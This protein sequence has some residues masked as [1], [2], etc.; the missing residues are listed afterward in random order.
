LTA[1]AIDFVDGLM[2]SGLRPVLWRRIV[3]DDDALGVGHWIVKVTGAY[4]TPDAG[5]EFDVGTT[6]GVVFGRPDDVPPPPP[7]PAMRAANPKSATVALVRFVKR[8]I[9]D[10]SLQNHRAYERDVPAD[11]RDRKAMRPL[12]ERHKNRRAASLKRSNGS[13]VNKGYLI[14]GRARSSGLLARFAAA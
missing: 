5:A 4:W 6:P 11:A 3:E 10:P 2:Y 12:R 1:I 8:R 9:A 14:K 13:S 7:Q